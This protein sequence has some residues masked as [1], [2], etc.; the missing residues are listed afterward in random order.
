MGHR[1]GHR[2]NRRGHNPRLVPVTL[3]GGVGSRCPPARAIVRAVTAT[4]HEPGL[5]PSHCVVSY[6]SALEV[7]AL[8]VGLSLPGCT[9]RRIRRGAALASRLDPLA[10]SGDKRGRCKALFSLCSTEQP[11]QIQNQSKFRATQ[12]TRHTDKPLRVDRKRYHLRSYQLPRSCCNCSAARLAFRM[13]HDFCNP[14]D[15][16]ALGDDSSF[17]A[18]TQ[19]Q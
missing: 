11:S 19:Q 18:V 3:R 6:G 10:F 9:Q 12:R 17:F 16:D 15:P 2:R 1:D 5:S 7:W 14:E 13:A 4:K 8:L